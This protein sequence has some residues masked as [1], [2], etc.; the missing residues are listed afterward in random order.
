[1]LYINVSEIFIKNLNFTLYMI[2]EG[3]V[4]KTKGSIIALVEDKEILIRPH[5]DRDEYSNVYH[6]LRE[7]EKV[8]IDAAQGQGNLII[9]FD[10]GNEDYFFQRMFGNEPPRRKDMTFYQTRIVSALNRS[11]GYHTSQ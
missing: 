5:Q 11:R 2:L 10:T 7:G 8:F 4:K 9:N 6:R 3:I 1:M